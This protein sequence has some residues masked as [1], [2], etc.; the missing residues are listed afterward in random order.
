[1][2][3]P[4]SK[5]IV[6][7]ELTTH[8]DHCI[9]FPLAFPQSTWFADKRNEM[10]RRLQAT[11]QKDVIDQGALLETIRMAMPA[12][13]TERGLEFEV[14]GAKDTPQ[15][16]VFHLFT[17]SL[18]DGRCH[19]FVPALGIEIVSDGPD[20]VDADVREH[21]R[22]EHMRTGRFA[23]LR[24]MIACQWYK[25]ARLRHFSIELQ[26][27]G[28]DEQ[29]QER[30]QALLPE[31]AVP[32][33]AVGLDVAG[34]DAVVADLA[35]R[36]EGKFARSVLVAGAESC[37][38][39]S[40]LHAYAKQRSERGLSPIWETSAVRLLQGLTRDGGWQK[41][42]AVLCN[43]LYDQA[44][45]LY[46]GHLTELFEVGQYEGNNVSIGAALRDQL[47][48]GRILLLA[49][50]TEAELA[51]LELRSAGYA[52]LF[53]AL[54]MPWWNE[55]E[56]QR[57]VTEA[58]GLRGR[59]HAVQVVAEA[60]EESILL[61]RRYSPYSGFPGKPIRFLE[62]LILQQKLRG[63]GVEREQV[64]RAFCAETGIPQALLDARMPL[65]TDAMRDFFHR[66][67]FGQPTAID[68]VCDTLLSIKATMTRAG[69]PIASL[70]LIGP[71]GV[72]KTETAKALAEYMFGDAERMLRFDMSEYSDAASVLRL[73]GDLGTDEG[74]LVTCIRQQPFSV[75]LF[76]EME[77]AHQ[78]FFD[79]LLQILGEGRLTGGKGQ[80]AN[81]CSAV[82]VMTSNIG[83]SEL[84]RR[85]L[86]MHP[87]DQD[88]DGVARH[89]E[90]AV[91]NYFRP[92]LFNRLDHIVPFAPLTNAQRRP[93]I[94]REL[95]LLR[96]R[97][98]IRER[99]M[100]L[101]LGDAV[102]DHLCAGGRR[103]A[104][105][106]HSGRRGEIPAGAGRGGG[107]GRL[108]P[109]RVGTALHGVQKHCARLEPA[110]GELLH[111]GYLRTGRGGGVIA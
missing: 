97:E 26:V 54:R 38:K 39:T 33:R 22:L 17:A 51:T 37:G 103:G 69:K 63:E 46:V 96:G 73:T 100:A 45:V 80:L 2:S 91:Q 7:A 64:M 30:V 11:L 109:D 27:L 19:S 14:P 105:L 72:G 1:M 79:L 110:G 81:F 41:N 50:G 71:T 4:V 15:R 47:Q 52:A 85:P 24:K 74:A 6:V 61:Q 5:S 95:G 59:E 48:R 99:A 23:D 9:V 3:T 93:I 53:Q 92:E 49:E 21:I 25:E 90:H 78:S 35:N 104:S 57:V 40:L 75:V 16:E 76:D 102:V 43:E 101:E 13:F 12:E 20:A 106:R 55:E 42:L 62:S 44:L 107:C 18:K 68:L 88:R 70:L 84:Q 8:D 65:D 77:K 34:L 111:A 87:S 86:G 10:L 31:V 98:G 56:Q 82:I 58:I 83:A 66:R 36:V 28:P 60:V 29:V 94:A 108:R 32:M 89:F 67:I